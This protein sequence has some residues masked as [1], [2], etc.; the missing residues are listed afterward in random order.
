[1][2]PSKFK[3]LIFSL[4]IAGCLCFALS[5]NTSCDTPKSIAWSYYYCALDTLKAGD[6]DAAR[7]FLNKCQKDSDPSLRT[8]A[9]SLM[10]VIEKETNRQ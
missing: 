9:D 7:H 1:M 3:S 4:C 10:K 8:K 2:K 5:L 6:P